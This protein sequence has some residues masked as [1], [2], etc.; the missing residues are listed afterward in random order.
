MQTLILILT[1]ALML[2]TDTILTLILT[3]ILILTL[4]VR[5]LD[6]E[7]YGIKK[8]RDRTTSGG[9]TPHTH[10]R[11]GE[12]VQQAGRIIIVDRGH[13]DVDDTTSAVEC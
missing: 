11:C 6:N 9:S 2:M 8:S 12:I 3:P 7:C 10:M 5:F 1:L 13:S 4:T